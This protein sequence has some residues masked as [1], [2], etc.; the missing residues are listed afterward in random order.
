MEDE[1]FNFNE[2]PDWAETLIAGYNPVNTSY[3]RRETLEK[4]NDEVREKNAG[5]P[6][7]IINKLFNDLKLKSQGI[8]KLKIDNYN[9][10]FQSEM[11]LL[12]TRET[13]SSVNDLLN[14]IEL[15]D[16]LLYTSPSPRD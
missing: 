3:D 9:Q 2:A 15:N 11:L 6:L 7:E 14:L 4:L 12:K 8:F 10:Y 13:K 1:F 16:C 5:I